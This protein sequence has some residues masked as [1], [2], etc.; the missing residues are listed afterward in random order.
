MKEIS[1]NSSAT[2]AAVTITG[3]VTVALSRN[4]R[5]GRTAVLGKISKDTT[6]AGSV[7]YD[8]KSDLLTVTFRPFST[9]T[10]E[11]MSEVGSR[12]PFLVSEVIK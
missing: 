6:E 7:S 2:Y 5:N 8:S 4:T 10:V 11:E 3:D 12:V 9:L 1:S